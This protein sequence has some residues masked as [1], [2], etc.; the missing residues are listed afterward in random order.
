MYHYQPGVDYAEALKWWRKAADQGHVGAQL[1]LGTMYRE[2]HG[3]P[4]ASA[5]VPCDSTL[6]HPASDFPSWD[7]SIG[8]PFQRLTSWLLGRLPSHAIV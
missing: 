4:P 1:D 8:F 6:R 2:G 3:V 7:L 5:T